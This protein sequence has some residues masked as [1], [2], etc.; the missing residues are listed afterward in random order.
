[1]TL[2]GERGH[3]A[4]WVART[5]MMNHKELPLWSCGYFV[6]GKKKRLQPLPSFVSASVPDTRCTGGVAAAP[7]R[8]GMAKSNGRAKRR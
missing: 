7:K 8:N 3:A 2:Q 1:M 5:N 6:S 4:Y